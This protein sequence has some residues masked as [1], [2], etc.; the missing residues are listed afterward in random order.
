MGRSGWHGNSGGPYRPDPPG[1]SLMKLTVFAATGG[2]GRQIVEQADAAG[3]D[4]TAVARNPRN[5]PDGVRV[6]RAD[7]ATAAPATLESAVEGADAVL[8]GLGRRTPADT[9]IAHHGTQAIVAAMTA[10][11]VRRLVVV[12]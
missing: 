1:S 9:G 3:H 6:I 4:I 7:L 5:L 10:A 12:S 2:I 11:D 8:S